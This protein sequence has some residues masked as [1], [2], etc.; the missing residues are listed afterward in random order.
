MG[1]DNVMTVL[2]TDSLYQILADRAHWRDEAKRVTEAA[3]EADKE[4][5]EQLADYH[6][7][8]NALHVLLGLDVVSMN[9]L[10]LIDALRAKLGTSGL[11]DGSALSSVDMPMRTLSVDGV[12][13]TGF[14]TNVEFN[15]WIVPPEPPTSEDIATFA[16]AVGGR[17][18][19]MVDTVTEQAMTEQAET[20]PTAAMQPV[21]Q[22]TPQRQ[23][24]KLG[25]PINIDR[26]PVAVMTIS[27]EIWDWNGNDDQGR[28]LYVNQDMTEVVLFTALLARCTVLDEIWVR[29]T[30]KTG[31]EQ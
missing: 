3:E 1:H 27:G 11:K 13:L 5:H 10:Q 20:E 17:A 24:F 7:L 6:G 9:D 30:T 26:P 12:E 31:A 15:G 21:E 22:P 8:R 19:A 14:V 18:A 4:W 25:D 28:P 29:E 16:A 23:R 2:E